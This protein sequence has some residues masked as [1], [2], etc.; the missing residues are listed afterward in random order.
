[1][2]KRAW[3]F[4][5][6]HVD[7]EDWDRVR[8]VQANDSEDAVKKFAKGIGDYD[9]WTKYVVRCGDTKPVIEGEP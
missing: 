7:G 5:T 2:S 6:G 9:W 4:V 3:Y 8:V 1:M